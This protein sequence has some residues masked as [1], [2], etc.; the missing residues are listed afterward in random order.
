MYASFAAIIIESAAIYSICSLLYLVPYTLNSPISYAFMQLLGEAQVVAPLLIIYRIALG[1]AWTTRSTTLMDEN[2][3]QLRRPSDLPKP[4]QA[5]PLNVEVSFHQ[6]T[7]RDESIR[8]PKVPYPMEYTE[9]FANE[10]DVFGR[11]V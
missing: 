8:S 5:A 4:P 6:E 10:T 11:A 2:S 1:K 9:D 7:A 3:I